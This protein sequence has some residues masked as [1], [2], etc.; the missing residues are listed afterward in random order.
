MGVKEK[1]IIILPLK[2]VMT[3]TLIE[4]L[5]GEKNID[6]IYHA[7]VLGIRDYFGKMGFSKAIMGASGGIDSAVTQVLAVQALGKENVRALL[8][9]SQF[10][11]FSFGSRC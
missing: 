1:H 7:I 8:M 9:P 6:E 2:S 3:K 11:I 10:S 4:Y 5:S